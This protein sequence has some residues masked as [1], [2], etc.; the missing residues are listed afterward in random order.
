MPVR[1]WAGLGLVLGAGAGL[2]IGS[3]VAGAPAL[4]IVL[5]AAAGLVLGSI[6]GSWRGG[7]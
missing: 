5:G 2:V 4:G 7:R 6:A 1:T 3:I